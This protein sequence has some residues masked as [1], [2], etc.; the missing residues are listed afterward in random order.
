M[1]VLM[2]INGLKVVTICGH[3]QTDFA[4]KTAAAESV[5]GLKCGVSGLELIANVGAAHQRR[6]T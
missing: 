5:A 6:N 2:C 4:K 1:N 3:T